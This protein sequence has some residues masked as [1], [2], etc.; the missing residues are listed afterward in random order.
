MPRELANVAERA[1]TALVDSLRRL[2][3]K[4]QQSDQTQMPSS[5]PS[6]KLS[7]GDLTEVDFTVQGRSVLVEIVAWEMRF[8]V[9]VSSIGVRRIE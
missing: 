3:L 8:G 4:M 5:R 1:R 6:L 2:R 7:A 9:T